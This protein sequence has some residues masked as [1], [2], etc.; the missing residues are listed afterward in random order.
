MQAD[1]VYCNGY[2]VLT[3]IESY[4]RQSKLLDIAS[5]ALHY[6]HAVVRNGQ[7]FVALSEDDRCTRHGR[8]FVWYLHGARATGLNPTSILQVSWSA[9]D[10]DTY[11]SLH[12]LSNTPQL[13]CMQRK[14]LLKVYHVLPR[15]V[16]LGRAYTMYKMAASSGLGADIYRPTSRLHCNK[17]F[18]A[19][20]TALNS[21][22]LPSVYAFQPP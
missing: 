20:T 22:P 5:S 14:I 21:S 18:R 12:A 1:R 10:P 19:P 6:L 2:S 8:M 7:L 15:V 9:A 11:S 16:L 13:P 4:G 3:Y 17:N